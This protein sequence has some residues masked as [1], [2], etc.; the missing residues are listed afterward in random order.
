[1][2]I[3]SRLLATSAVLTGGLSLSAAAFATTAVAATL[4]PAPFNYCP[5][6]NPA[7]YY[8]FSAVGTGGSF[9]MGSVTVTLPAGTQLQGGFVRDTNTG[10]LRF[11]AAS[12]SSR[13]LSSPGVSVPGG[14]LG[15]TQ[16]QDLI[17]GVTNVTAE[18]RLVGPADVSLVN[19]LSRRTPGIVLPVQVKL[20]NPLLGP[21]CTI[22]TPSKPILLNLTTGTTSPPPPA[23]PISGSQGAGGLLQDGFFFQGVSVVDN[24]WGA[25]GASGCGLFGILNGVVNFKSGLPSPPGNNYAIL[26]SDAYVVSAS[27]VFADA[28]YPGF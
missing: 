10:K 20:V 4:P 22:G 1:M 14:L 21:D 13:T 17:P 9:K 12:P 18:V 5:V 28:P 15:V 25:P 6:D 16:I 2:T 26:N 7:L 24:T 23:Q 8:C 27:R 3:R 11:V 19:V